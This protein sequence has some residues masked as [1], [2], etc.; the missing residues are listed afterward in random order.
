MRIVSDKLKI[1]VL[2]IKDVLHFRIDLHHR[3][4]ARLTRKLELHLL[5]MICIDV[6][7]TCSVNEFSWLKTT[8]L[9]DHHCK[10]RIG[11]DIERHSEEHICA[12]LIELA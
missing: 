9:S 3:K 1:F 11:S 12:A 5:E 10:K 7:V 2:E 8:Y 4:G 6:R